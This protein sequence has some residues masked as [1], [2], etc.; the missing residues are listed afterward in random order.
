MRSR[1]C[2]ALVCAETVGPLPAAPPVTTATE[3]RD[4]SGAPKFSLKG[5]RASVWASSA[6]TRRE[7]FLSGRRVLWLFRPRSASGA[8]ELCYS[9]KQ[10]V[11][12]K[13]ILCNVWQRLMPAWKI[14]PISEEIIPWTRIS[15][16][17]WR[18]VSGRSTQD[19]DWGSRPITKHKS[20]AKA[21]S[22]RT[23][24]DRSLLAR[25]PEYRTHSRQAQ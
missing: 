13:G 4:G 20:S 9:A 19:S 24:A 12:P 7:Y 25:T 8:N 11:W 14:E 17:N 6:L 10:A 21:S 18:N 3:F 2:A 1:W 5:Q 23:E 15:C 16:A 22:K